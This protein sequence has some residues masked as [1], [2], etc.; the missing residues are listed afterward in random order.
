MKFNKENNK[1]KSSEKLNDATDI[2]DELDELTSDEKDNENT[3]KQW[4]QDNLRII[5]SIF[6]VAL[7]AGGVYSYSKRSEAPTQK[8]DVISSSQSSKQ[9][10]QSDVKEQKSS[11]KKTASDEKNTAKKKTATTTKEEKSVSQKKT[12][13]TTASQETEKSFVETAAA[14]DSQTTL[15]REALAN[16]LTKNPDSSLTAEHKIYIEDYLRKNV[17]GNK[18]VHIGTSI[19]F[20]KS[21]IQKAI[22]QSKTLTDKQL[23]NL[24]KYVRR[25]SSFS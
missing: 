12:T 16:F 10:E 6:I 18:K 9:E 3:L 14:G 15:A 2:N 22:T 13:S 8:N 21:L 23:K 7:I 5:I 1:E 17:A 24:H 11:S 19:E 25:V 20:S 4:L